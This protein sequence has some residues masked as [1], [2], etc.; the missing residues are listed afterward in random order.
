MRYSELS[1][2]EKQLIASEYPYKADIHLWDVTSGQNNNTTK[3]FK[4]KEEL[5]EF[6]EEAAED[7]VTLM[8]RRDF[9]TSPE[10]TVN[11]QTVSMIDTILSPMGEEVYRM[12]LELADQEFDPLPIAKSLF[13]VQINRLQ[14]GMEYEKDVDLGLSPETEACY[15][16]LLSLLKITNDIVNGQKVDVSLNGSLS[17]MI[18]DMDI[19]SLIGE[20]DIIDIQNTKR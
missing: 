11:S 1:R 20:D 7:G 16:N 18:M 15:G 19:D 5:M 4:T 8:K 13:A 9:V 6:K 14:R 3:F 2:K 10:R 12:G 17:S